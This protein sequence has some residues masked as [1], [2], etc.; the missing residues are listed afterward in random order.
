MPSFAQVDEQGEIV[1][2][3]PNEQAAEMLGSDPSEGYTNPEVASRM[4]EVV[5]D[6]KDLVLLGDPE[7]FSEAVLEMVGPYLV[8]ADE[9]TT[10]KFYGE[11]GG[12]T[13]PSDAS[14]ITTTE[15]VSSNPATG[16]E[17]YTTTTEA[18][19]GDQAEK[20]TQQTLAKMLGT[21]NSEESDALM[22]IIAG[23][24]RR[25]GRG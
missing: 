5:A 4:L 3:I 16:E 10:E 14:G 20:V 25:N 17:S 2:V 1:A 22:D 11:E 21:G 9:A 23:G 15:T 13:L 12:D 24:G 18:G 8:D 7:R 6:S 19:L